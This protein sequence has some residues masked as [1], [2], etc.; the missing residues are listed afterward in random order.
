MRWNDCSYTSNGFRRIFSRFDN[1]DAVFVGF[2]SF[3]VIA[4]DC[5]CLNRP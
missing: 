1:L 5:C 3:S 2:A 4:D